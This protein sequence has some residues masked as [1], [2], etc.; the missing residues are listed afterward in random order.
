MVAASSGCDTS[1]PEILA[2]IRLV[3]FSTFISGCLHSFDEQRGAT[4]RFNRINRRRR[5]DEQAASIRAAKRAGKDV[6]ARRRRNFSNDLPALC[7]MTE[8]VVGSIGDP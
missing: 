4:A 6:K 3:S 2:P 5:A 7:D 8:P 1:I